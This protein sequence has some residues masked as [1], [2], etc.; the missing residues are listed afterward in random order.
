MKDSMYVFTENALNRKQQS[1]N[2]FVCK[3]V[4]VSLQV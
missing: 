1:P 4:F 2:M 3:E